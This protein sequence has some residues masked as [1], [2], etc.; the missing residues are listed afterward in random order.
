MLNFDINFPTRIHFGRGKIQ[1]L[2]QEVLVY[3]NKVLLVYGGGSIKR[4][5]LY[6]QVVNIFRD[7]GITHVEL[8]GVQ[9]NPRISSVRQ[10]AELCKEHGIQLV[11]AVGGGSTIDCAKIIAAGAGY[12][13]DAWDFFTRRTRINSALPVGCILT[14][15]ATGSE[16][17]GNAVISNDETEQKL[18]TGS[19]LLIPRFSILDP[20]YTF[21]VPPEQ[22][23]AGTVD[24]MSHIFE[25]YFSPTP[26]TFIQDRLAEA[27][28][29]TC[30]HYGPLAITEPDNYE[31]RANLMWTGTLALNGLLA[32]GKRTDWA[33]HDIEHEISAIYDITHGLGLAILT[34]YWMHYVLDEQ[35][36]P[37]LAEYGRCVWGIEGTEDLI[38]A[39]AA[40]K[41]TAEFFH[42]LNLAGSLS[43][44]GV[45]AERLAEMA[46]KA[47]ARGPLGSFRKL[48]FQDVLQILQ[49]A[50]DE[51][52]GAGLTY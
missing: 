26:G 47:T 52:L 43:E 14:L 37:R 13:G 1:E 40:I 38:V 50:Y 9:P 20:E 4:N 10:G 19:P 24:I 7:T 23:A 49:T 2:A 18:G 22:T 16:M 48:E 5:G 25:Q 21:S 12:E 42:S 35:T 27:M 32:A 15:A 11:L 46:E 31:A 51:L 29:K 39:Q 8:S 30:I 41:K 44:I 28:L 17:N 3:G 36:A 6:E 33:T 45:E 34:P